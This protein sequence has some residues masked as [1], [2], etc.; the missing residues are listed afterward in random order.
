MNLIKF[1]RLVP[2][3]KIPTYAKPG[4][5][6]L[7]VYAVSKEIDEFGNISYGTGLA[8]EFDN[9]FGAF[10]F[11]RSSVSK[12]GLSLANC[13]GVIDSGY[14]GEIIFKFRKINSLPEYEIGDKIGQI[15]M[16]PT[17]QFTTKEFTELSSSERGEGGF[18][19]TGV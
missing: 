5:K 11:P 2:E 6:G 17:P 18:G 14:R 4:D 16:I 9:E 7:D 13:I 15:V 1:K 8:M 10:L 3:A 12:Y 19:S